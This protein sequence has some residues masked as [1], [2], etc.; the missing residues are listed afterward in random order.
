MINTTLSED[1]S[2]V[3][4]AFGHD[5]DTLRKL[6]GKFKLVPYGS[7]INPKTGRKHF[8]VKLVQGDEVENVKP[9]PEPKRTKVSKPKQTQKAPQEPIQ[10]PIQESEEDLNDIN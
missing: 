1:G 5:A 3:L 4:S 8:I 2:I 7:N 9:T 10:E 6:S